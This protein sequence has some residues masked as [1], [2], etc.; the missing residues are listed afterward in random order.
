MKNIDRIARLISQNGAGNLL[1]H[2]IPGASHWLLCQKIDQEKWAIA[3]CNPIG[4]A[5]FN[6]GTITEA[7]HLNLWQELI[8]LDIK[9][10]IGIAEKAKIYR[11][12][13]RNFRKIKNIYANFIK[14]NNQK[15]RRTE[16]GDIR[17]PSGIRDF[18]QR[19]SKKSQAYPHKQERIH[20]YPKQYRQF[21]ANL[22]R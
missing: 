18:A 19:W 11:N 8:L 16:K 9:R 6:L 20:C 1:I 14:K 5:T 10:R 17:R 3:L 7:E 21:A 13:I 2:S 12:T 15:R 4:N 22:M